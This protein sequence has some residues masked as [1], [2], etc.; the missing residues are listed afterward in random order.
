MITITDIRAAGF[1][2][3]GVK[4]W[5]AAQGWDFKAFLRDGMDDEKFLSTGDANAQRVVDLKAERN[6]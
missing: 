3:S 5:F 1:C 2:V 6:G 4:D